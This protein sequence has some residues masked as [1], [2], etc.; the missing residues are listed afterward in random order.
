MKY[1][2]KL[3]QKTFSS[4]VGDFTICDFFTRY[5]VNHALAQTQNTVVDNSF[6]LIELSQNI[7]QDNNSI[8]LFLLANESIDPF[9]LTAQNPTDYNNQTKNKISTALKSTLL[10]AP[11]DTYTVGT[12]VTKYVGATSG[13]KWEYSYVGNFSLTGPFT[14]IE[15]TDYYVGKMI[16]KEPINGTLIS[17][18]GSCADSLSIIS[19]PDTGTTYSQ[20][21]GENT[22][23]N[24]IAA[25]LEIAVRGVQ[26]AGLVI[27]TPAD[28]Q[29]P[30]VPFFS[31]PPV[32]PPPTNTGAGITLTNLQY[33]INQNKNIKV[34]LPGKLAN[35]LSN[36]VTF[37]S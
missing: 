2:S 4:T 14:L 12:I 18:T 17:L 32:P 8:W 11:V 6:T 36:L 9:S 21:S 16:L 30:Q 20:V 25:T 34:F 28:D 29:Y 13:K 19:A 31:G 1:F 37:S 22:T 27:E 5:E 10:G 3:P 15:S 24:K 23:Q 35:I 33:V 7:Y 26:D